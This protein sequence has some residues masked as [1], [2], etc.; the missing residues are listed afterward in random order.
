MADEKRISVSFGAFAVE[1]EGYDDPFS[2]LSTVISHMKA[3]S[4]APLG[5][6]AFGA[7]DLENADL[8]A[9]LSQDAARLE[10]QEGAEAP[11]LR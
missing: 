4:D 10:L 9:S 6:R 5:E 11:R 8:L 2:V 1:I 3:A 7:A